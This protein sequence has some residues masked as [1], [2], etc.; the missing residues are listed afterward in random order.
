MSESSKLSSKSSSKLIKPS[1]GIPKPTAQQNLNSISSTSITSNLAKSVSTANLNPEDFGEN[2][3]DFKLNDRVWVNGTKPGYIAFIGETQFKEGVWAGII[4]DSNDGK[5]N[6]TINNVTYFKTEE[7]RGVFCRLNKITRT[8][9]EPV[10][11]D[12]N[13]QLESGSSL[14]IGCRVIIVNSDGST[15]CG[16][17]RYIGG[18]EFAKGE[19][20]GVE[21]DEKLGKN[22]GS[23]S[24][25]RYFQCEPLYGVFAPVHKVHLENSEELK[26]SAK[27][28]STSTPRSSTKVSGLSKKHSGSHESLISEKSSI[29]STISTANKTSTQRKLPQKHVPVNIFLNYIL[30]NKLINKK[31]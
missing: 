11:Q 2:L 8:P 12:S 15:K 17:L 19:W 18:T 7:N 26:T 22:D 1:V 10:Q 16:V 6:G 27:T 20:A 13:K 29:I 31:T 4:L 25:K 9:T 3:N 5:N 14:K 23:V 24:N 30:E 21:L 28:F